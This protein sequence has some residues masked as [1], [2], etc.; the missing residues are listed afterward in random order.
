MS[1]G[2]FDRYIVIQ[3]PVQKRGR[4]GGVKPQWDYFANSW[5]KKEDVS[6]GETR[7]GTQ[8]VAETNVVFETR[9]WIE[10]LTTAHRIDCDGVAHDIL[11]I[12]EIGRKEAAEIQTVARATD[13]L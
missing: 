5:A 11:F 6:G 3:N 10:G 7:R 2:L 9:H 12:R 8:L 4:A 13:K 1:A